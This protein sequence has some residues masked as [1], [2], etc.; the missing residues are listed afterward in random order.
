MNADLN[1]FQIKLCMI[2]RSKKRI[3]IET[4]VFDD[5]I[6]NGPCYKNHQIIFTGVLAYRLNGDL[7]SSLYELKEMTKD[8]LAGIEN[9]F[10]E[11]L[12]DWKVR[13]KGAKAFRI[14][15]DHGLDEYVICGECVINC[16]NT[17]E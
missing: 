3:V 4:E 12:F 7:E 15:S 5:D 11:A 8:E 16:I 2:Y 13:S 6:K 9:D 10:L 14:E 17:K 1:G